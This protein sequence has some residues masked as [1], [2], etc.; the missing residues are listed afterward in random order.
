MDWL[1]ITIMMVA[2]KA[3]ILPRANNFYFFTGRDQWYLIHFK[4]M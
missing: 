3:F 4:L 1:V 2:F